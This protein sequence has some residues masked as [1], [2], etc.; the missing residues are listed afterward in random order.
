VGEEEKE[1]YDELENIADC[2]VVTLNAA[3]SK[4]KKKKR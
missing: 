2:L 4:K 1:A 3:S